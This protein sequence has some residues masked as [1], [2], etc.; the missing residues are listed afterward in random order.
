MDR[1]RK[2][3]DIAR[4]Q[5]DRELDLE[6]TPPVDV[7][8]SARARR[9]PPPPAS[10]AP[11]AAS[12]AQAWAVEPITYS[13][14]QVFTPP[15]ATLE[16]NRILDPAASN[17]AAAAFRMLRT[18]VLQRLDEN[19]WRTM[20]VLSPRAHDGKT[21]TAV[22]LALCLANDRRHTVLL[23][24]ADLKRPSVAAAFGLKPERGL[25]DVLRGDAQIGECLYHPEGVERLVLLP[26]RGP[27]ANSSE[28][29]AGPMGRAVVAELRAR[30]PERLLIFDLPPI[31][32]A[33]DAVAFL[34]LVECGLIVVAERG[35]PRDDLVRSMELVRKTPIVG[36]V[37]NRASE[38]TAGYG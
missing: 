5:R 23:V 30:Y 10:Q 28:V 6:E 21:T 32:N 8:T 15:P 24:D 20:A 14:T 7:L 36:T 16:A 31:L 25:D 38:L 9:A 18:Q 37:L 19:G 13:Q 29:L 33:D 27:L 34:P 3:L 2:A 17:P 26:S 11:A 22:N 35:T 12:V 1:I 4:Q